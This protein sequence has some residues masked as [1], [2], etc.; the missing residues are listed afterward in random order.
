MEAIENVKDIHLTTVLLGIGGILIILG[1]KRFYKRIPGPLVAVA[2]GIVLVYF[3]GLDSNGVKIVKEVPAGFPPFVFPSFNL[4]NIQALL[5]TALTISLIGFMES[6]AVAKAIQAKHKNYKLVPNQELVALGIANIGGSLFSSFPTT[7]GFSRTAVNDQSGA[8]TGMASIISATL[9]VLTLLFLT[10][11]FYYLP[12]ALLASVIMVAV[13]G[14]IDFKEM[15]HLWKTDKRDFVMLAATFFATLAL[16]IEEGI[17]IGV[18]LSIA[19][20]IK[21]SSYPHHA[22]LGKIDRMNTYRNVKRFPDAMEIDGVLMFRFD[23]QLF[24]ANSQIFR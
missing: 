11:L 4:E 6:I 17:L 2:L 20:I 7:G 19:L 18:G 8:K 5:P 24:F 15:V 10:P 22:I 14:L 12:K 23:A 13:F 1:F 3:F 16:G 9:I 21:Q